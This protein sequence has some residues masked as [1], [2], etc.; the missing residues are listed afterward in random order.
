GIYP[1]NERRKLWERVRSR[2]RR[3]V[4]FDV[5]EIVQGCEVRTKSHPIYMAGSI[6]ISFVTGTP[7]TPEQYDA[8][9]GEEG[10]CSQTDKKSAVNRELI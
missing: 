4:T 5:T 2:S 9:T 1:F 7:M 6:A 10:A 3:H 8:S